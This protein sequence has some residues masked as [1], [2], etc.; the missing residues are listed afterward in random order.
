VT[1]EPSVDGTAHLTGLDLPPHKVAAVTRRINSIARSLRGDGETRS[2]DQLRADVYLDLLQGTKHQTKA[3]G[4]V[5]LTVDLD[6][7]T[8]LTEHPGNDHC[9]ELRSNSQGTPEAFPDAACPPRTATSTTPPHSQ[10]TD[11]PCQTT[12]PPSAAET[13]ASDTTDG[14]TRHSPTAQPN[15]QAPSATPTPHGETHHRNRGRLPR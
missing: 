14:P 7:L 4:V 1:A 5:H 3:R 8:G 12:S 9:P 2:M 15:G 13:T 6:T 11:P 10:N